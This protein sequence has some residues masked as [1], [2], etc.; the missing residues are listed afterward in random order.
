MVPL[1]LKLDGEPKLC[2]LGADGR[3]ITAY[4]DHRAMDG[5]GAEVPQQRTKVL[6]SALPEA[7]P[8]QSD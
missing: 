4:F 6:P 3:L 1:I 2:E 8:V 5:W 7:A